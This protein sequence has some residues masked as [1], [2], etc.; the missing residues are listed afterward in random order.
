MNIAELISNPLAQDPAYHLFADQRTLLGVPHFWNVISN[1]PFLAVGA[2]GLRIVA[3]DSA[4]PLR[5]AW[6][7]VFIGVFLTGLG[8]AWYHLAPDNESLFWDRLA[9]TIGFMGL[10][11]GVIGEYVSARLANRLL[12][13][14]LIVG[15]AS[16]VYWIHTES[17]GAGDLRAYAIVQ[18][19]PV[20]ALPLIIIARP[21]H[22][23]LGRYLFITILAYAV[24]KAAEVYDRE[25]YAATQMISGHTLK[26][27]LAAFGLSALVVGLR[28]RQRG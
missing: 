17:I 5:A 2:W 16:V 22:S 14:L 9:M 25:V 15:T 20:I 19:V 28:R 8:S 24:A 23:D 18:F 10:V 1:L 26:H 6:L 12:L 7:T 13:P 27:L 3:R 11:A 21:G 4:D